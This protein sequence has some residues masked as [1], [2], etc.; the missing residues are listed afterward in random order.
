MQATQS[1]K[2]RATDK[3]DSGE[4]LEVRGLVFE[5]EPLGYEDKDYEEAAKSGSLVKPV[6]CISN[7]VTLRVIHFPLEFDY[8]V[9]DNLPNLEELHIGGGG[10]KDTWDAMSHSLQWMICRNLPKL[11]K[12]TV[13]C[14]VL[15]WLEI[16]GAESLQS[17][18]LRKAGAIDRLSILNAPSVKK[19]DV[20]GCKKLK[21]ISGMHPDKQ[22]ELGVTDQIE[23]MQAN[24]KCD[25]TLYKNMSFTDVEHVLWTINYGVKIASLKG[26]FHGDE[27]FCYGREDD[28]DFNNFSFHLLRPLEFVYTG[29]TGETYAYEAVC[30]D[31]SNGKYGA[32]LG[33][34]NST[35]EE[36]LDQALDTLSGSDL[37]IPGKQD[38]TNMQ[39]LEFLNK[40]VA[41]ETRS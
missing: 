16:D 22:S 9:F 7:D 26:L 13:N 31:F 3:S 35:Q 4:V 12:I 36:C 5:R 33:V 8:V 24:S 29:G 23:S 30:H 10:P 14:K 34:G 20:R 11:K 19:I 37:N 25:G 15:R 40:L 6:V 21:E 18:D 39:I 28:P 38:P 32:Y 27:D 1:S 17:I 2:N 41:K